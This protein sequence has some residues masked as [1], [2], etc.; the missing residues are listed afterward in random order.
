MSCSCSAHLKALQNATPRSQDVFLKI[1]APSSKPR[2]LPRTYIVVPSQ[3]LCYDF[4]SPSNFLPG[5]VALEKANKLPAIGNVDDHAE[6]FVEALQGLRLARVI[7]LGLRL[8]SQS[9]LSQISFQP[10]VLPNL[11]APAMPQR[12]PQP[13]V[14]IPLLGHPGKPSEPVLVLPDSAS[15]E[16]CI[17][18]L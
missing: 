7:K 10:I 11:F 4:W 5:P 2:S 18:L 9:A 1:T 12:W 16:I 3:H 17:T 14:A 6:H 15:V 8:N 13:Q